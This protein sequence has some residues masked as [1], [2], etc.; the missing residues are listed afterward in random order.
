MAETAAAP[1]LAAVP[2]PPQGGG[3][4]LHAAIPPLHLSA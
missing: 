4:P 2:S 1:H 3:T